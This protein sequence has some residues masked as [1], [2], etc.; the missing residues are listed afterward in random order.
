MAHWQ[1][2][3]SEID[4][5]SGGLWKVQTLDR[6]RDSGDPGLPAGCSAESARV[7]IQS[8]ETRTRRPP[9]RRRAAGG[10]GSESRYGKLE[11]KT[12]DPE[13]SV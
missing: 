1:G 3:W 13:N 11:Y 10:P 2:S 6:A 8:P 5:E 9:G 12:N 7:G 4:S